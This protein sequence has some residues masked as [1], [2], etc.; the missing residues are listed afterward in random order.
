M[1]PGVTLLE[2]APLQLLLEMNVV[3]SKTSE[4]VKTTVPESCKAPP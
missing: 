1:P 4:G 2:G 3:L